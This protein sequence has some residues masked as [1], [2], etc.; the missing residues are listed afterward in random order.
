[1]QPMNYM[2]DVGN[3]IASLQQGYQLGA[4]IRNDIQKQQEAEAQRI[5]AKRQSR[6]QAAVI[7]ELTSNPTA[8]NYAKAMLVMPGAREQLKSS[9]ELRNSAAIQNDVNEAGQ[10]YS[11]IKN[12]AVD[13]AKQMLQTRLAGLENSGAPAREIQAV[14]AMSQLID[15]NPQMVAGQA[16]AV[17]Q[18]APGGDKILS[19]IATGG[20]EQREQDLQ[21][22]LVR[23]GVADAGAAEVK[24]RFAESEAV[25]DLEKK[26]W[27]IKKIKEDID[28]NKQN[29]RIA[30][31][32]ASLAREGNALKRQE[33]QM[34]MDDAIAARDEKVRG[35]VAEATTAIN[36]VNSTAGVFNDILSDEDTLR[37]AVG[38]SAWRGSIP[39]T[40]TR[41]MAGKLEQ[42][43]NMMTAE[44][45]GLLKG[46]MS[47]NDIKFLRN[48][49]TNLDRYQ[50]EDSFLSEMKRVGK[51]LAK[52][53]NQI[54]KKYGAPIES[55]DLPSSEAPSSS[56]VDA[57]LKKYGGG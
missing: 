30:A 24:A 25:L 48:I 43:Q 33:I 2:I 16:L 53:Q 6:E 4:G 9:F 41:S 1:M 35:K 10:L 12:G 15:Q 49:S 37:A 40:K 50:D 56:E 29:A 8:D 39:G 42:L 46:A 3:P 19:A 34:K 23:K 32:N 21:P 54:A 31:M 55:F 44:N 17:L 45:L 52:A 11:A 22:S 26:G 36:A 57:L 5:E 14:R 13:V 27:D 7:D 20:K 38:T 18:T 47:D 51:N 28:I